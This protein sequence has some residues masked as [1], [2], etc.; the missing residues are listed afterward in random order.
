MAQTILYYPYIDIQD[1]SWLRNAILYW[2]EIS[3]IVPNNA[4]RD[5]STEI[6]YL[7]ESGVYKAIYPQ[8]LFFTQ[9]AEEFWCTFKKRIEIYERSMTRKNSIT[10][11]NRV[12]IHRNKINASYLHELIR[13]EK[14]PRTLMDFLKEKSR[15]CGTWIE[16]EDKVAQ[17]YMKTLAE[18]LIKS[19]DKDIVL[20]T[21]TV[22][23]N[24]EIYDN[25]TSCITL[26]TQCCKI[27][28]EKCLP[29][30]SMDVSF[31]DILNFKENRKDELKALR[32]KIRELEE[33]I[34]KADSMEL[35]KHYEN[36]FIESWE[37]C[38]KDFHKVLKEARI[39]FSL[40]SLSSLVA[41]PFVGELLSEHI[42]PDF[43]SAIQTVTPL[44]NIT[45]GYFNYRNKISP[46]KSDG[47]FSYI[48]QANKEGIIHMKK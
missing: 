48:I 36:Q 37:N 40:G 28:I 20:G 19:S 27:N 47:G 29:Q 45:V 39:A 30:P 11:D 26:K 23:H 43:T 7:K 35:I 33:N 12:R 3:S 18:Y 13:N 24:Q 31:E 44:L 22:T 9:S 41:I 8:D 21:D 15:N 32:R 34:Y 38:S 16:V 1:S 6:S 14:L 42:N 5:F 25:A 10:Q 2:D 17:I 46:V 4:Y